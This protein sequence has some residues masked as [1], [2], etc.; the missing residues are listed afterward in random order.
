MKRLDFAVAKPVW[1]K[2]LRK[3]MNITL[4]FTYKIQTDTDCILRLSGRNLW[5]VFVDGDFFAA[6]PARTAQGYQR[7]DELLIPPCKKLEI[8]VA[9]YNINSYYVI[10]DEGSVMSSKKFTN[11]SQRACNTSQATYALGSHHLIP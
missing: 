6:G 1:A 2:G 9:G 11:E 7:V 8:I 5:Q 4:C 3:E 10:P